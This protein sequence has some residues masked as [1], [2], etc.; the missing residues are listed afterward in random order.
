MPGVTTA[1]GGM[2]PTGTMSS[3]SAIVSVA[4]IAISGL[5]LRAVSAYSR[6]PW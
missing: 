5:K 2:L 1:S 3:A 4:A 6:L